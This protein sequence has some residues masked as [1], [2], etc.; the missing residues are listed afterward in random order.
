MAEK[1]YNVEL[2]FILQ[3][4][5]HEYES[6]YKGVSFYS[7]VSFTTTKDKI[8]T[9]TME[10]FKLKEWEINLLFY[11]MLLDKYLKSIDPLTISLEGLVFINNGG[12]TRKTEL[13]NREK[14]RLDA[15]Q[16]D[17]NKY[18]FG[19]MIFTAIVALGTLI[20]AWY[21]AIEI[22]KFYQGVH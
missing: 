21:F 11:T 2:D 22:Y 12:Y 7:D 19:L 10:K 8:T 6:I 14:I 1:N 16:K 3:Q 17:L 5:I 18:S 4:L 20:S 9:L 15:I 13:Q